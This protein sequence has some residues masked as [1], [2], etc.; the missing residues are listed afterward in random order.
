MRK[1]SGCND[2]GC[3]NNDDG[4]ALNATE[5]PLDQKANIPAD[6]TIICHE[7]SQDI[8]KLKEHQ[9]VTSLSGL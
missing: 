5:K 2:K 1:L 7:N 9:P 4:G 3:T 6:D 8:H